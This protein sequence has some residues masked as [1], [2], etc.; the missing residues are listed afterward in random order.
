[1]PK[2]TKHGEKR[3]SERVYATDNAAVRNAKKALKNG[4]R[5]GETYGSLKKWLDGKFLGGK[6]KADQMRIYMGRLYVF[7]HGILVTVF[8]LPEE[9]SNLLT[10]CVEPEAYDKYESQLNFQEVKRTRKKNKDYIEKCDAFHRLVML[11]DI[12]QFAEARYPV[13]I[14]GVGIERIQVRV[15]YIPTEY[16][17]PDLSGIADYIKEHTKYKSVRLVHK[18]DMDGKPEYSIKERIC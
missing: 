13:E 18:K 7:S 3:I 4:I 12:R 8:D 11:N 9:I 10:E 5:H 16:E 1:M 2:L 14:S 15:Y 6:S 17:I